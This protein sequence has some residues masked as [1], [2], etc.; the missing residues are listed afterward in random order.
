MKNTNETKPGIT[1][2]SG[3]PYRTPTL[4]I[5]GSIAALTNAV[6]NRGTLDNGT[7]PGMSKTY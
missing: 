4:S 5:Y 2:G 3:I 1:A 7:N 6:G